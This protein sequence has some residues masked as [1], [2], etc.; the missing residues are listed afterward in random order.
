MEESR[1]ELTEAIAAERPDHWAEFKVALREIIETIVLSLAIFFLITTFLFQNFRVVGA[2][3]EPSLHDGEYL[4]VNKL[5]YRF[6]SPQRGDIVVFAFPG[7]EARDFIKRIVGLPGD[8]VRIVKG[9]LK[10]NGK[11]VKEP[12]LDNRSFSSWGPKV[13]GESEYFVLG[14][15]RDNSSD[16][17]NWGMLPR[18]NIMGKAWVCYW[19]PGCWGLIPGISFAAER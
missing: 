8:K 4:I 6:R 7:D 9:R 14:D 13:L 1:E 2:S 18:A 16:S 5:V 19:P 3:M 10:I 15:N 11:R 12:Y 17:R